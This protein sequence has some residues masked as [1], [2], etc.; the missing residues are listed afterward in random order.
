[1]KRWITRGLLACLLVLLVAGVG[2]FAC[3]HTLDLQFMHDGV[4]G[5]R[6]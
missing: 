5:T 2:G 1:M 4:R 3:V 6:G